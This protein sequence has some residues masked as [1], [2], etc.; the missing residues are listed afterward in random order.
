MYLY[1]GVANLTSEML[2]SSLS[3]CPGGAILITW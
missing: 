3:N 1:V 2:G